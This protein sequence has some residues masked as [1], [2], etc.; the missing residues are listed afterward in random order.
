[1]NEKTKAQTRFSGVF[2]I[3]ISIVLAAMCIYLIYRSSATGV[4]LLPIAII[5]AGIGLKAI[6]KAKLM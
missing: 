5:C 3:A 6:N 4:A 2:L 1:M